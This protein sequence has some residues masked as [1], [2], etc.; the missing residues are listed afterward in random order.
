MQQPENYT[1]RVWYASSRE[2]RMMYFPVKDPKHAVRLINAMTD[3]DLLNDEI[4]YN[5]FGLEEYDPLS[6]NEEDKWSEW[7]DE[8][9]RSI[10]EYENWIKE[11]VF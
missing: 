10:E 4:G 6:E 2:E 3:S 11:S 5:A 1:L 8:K 7:R 9:D